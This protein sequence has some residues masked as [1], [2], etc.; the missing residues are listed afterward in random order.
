MFVC[1]SVCLFFI[2]F[3][4]LR[5]NAPKLSRNYPL[6]QE[7]VVGYFFPEK[8]QSFPPEMPNYSS[9]QW[10]CSIQPCRRNTSERFLSVQK[11]C[12]RGSRG[13]WVRFCGPLGWNPIGWLRTNRNSSPQKLTNLSWIVAETVLDG[14]SE[15]ASL[16]PKS[17]RLE[18]RLV[19]GNRFLTTSLSGSKG[20]RA[21]FSPEK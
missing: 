4:T 13:W 11:T 17:I 10:D 9:D 12:H 18:I 20:C 3:R 8:T 21:A 1:L 19:R 6:I 16:N 2:R 14:F 5:P 7:K 15:V